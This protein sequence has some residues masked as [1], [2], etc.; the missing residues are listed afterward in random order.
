MNN[1]I[2]LRD[3]VAEVCRDDPWQLLR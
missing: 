2:R 3:G 1:L